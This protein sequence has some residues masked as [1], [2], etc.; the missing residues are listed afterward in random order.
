[1]AVSEHERV[2]PNAA[3][4]AI[5]EKYGMGVFPPEEMIAIAIESLGKTPAYG[6]RME[7]PEGGDVSW[8]IHCGEY[9]AATDFYQP[10][11]VHHVSEM[12]PLVIKYLCLPT[13]AKF[14]IDT[15]G[16]EDVWMA[17]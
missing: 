12:L 17:E 3:Q 9:S 8:F 2:Y 13:G 14:I 7:L 10:I 16:Y 5:C 15:Q 11:H 6:T 1:V 4:K